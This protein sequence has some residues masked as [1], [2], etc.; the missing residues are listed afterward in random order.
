M[1]RK[2][3]RRRYETGEDSAEFPVRSF[4]I[5]DAIHKVSFGL[6]PRSPDL[7]STD[8]N[9]NLD[10]EAKRRYHPDIFK[11]L[12]HAGQDPETVRRQ[13]QDLDPEERGI[14]AYDKHMTEGTWV[15]HPGVALPR[16]GMAPKTEQFTC[17]RCGMP[18]EDSK[19]RIIPK[20]IEPFYQKVCD[21]PCQDWNIGDDP[22]GAPRRVR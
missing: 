16:E 17:P 11:A 5:P 15:I 1:A 3:F 20:N 10:D 21:P 6:D 8:S 22:H 2:R 9:G 19:G 7:G 18:I 4:S 13:E 12:F 14:G